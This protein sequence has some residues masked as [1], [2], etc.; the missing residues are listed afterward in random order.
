MACAVGIALGNWQW[1]RAEEKRAAA[2]V[3]KRVSLRGVFLPEYTVYA[4]NRLHRGRPGFHVV[5]PLRT[6]TGEHVLVNRGWLAAPAGARG[7]PPPVT[8]PA[9]EV[10]IAGVARARLPR[11]LAAGAGREGR[12]WQNV[13]IADFAA[14]SGLA[15]APWVLEQ[16]SAL[17]D[18]LVRDWPR[19]DEGADKN[20]AYALQWYS[21]AVLAVVLFVVLSVRR[22]APPAG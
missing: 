11:A 15:L 8:T 16:H 5:Q 17:A 14:W 19:A 9:G 2:A 7:A 13:E 10:E 18:G 4:D 12:V 22:D 21:L 20:R 1:Q 6:D 3:Q